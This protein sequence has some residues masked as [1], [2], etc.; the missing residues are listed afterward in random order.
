MLDGIAFDLIKSGAHSF[1]LRP[2]L[3]AY[4]KLKDK[5]RERHLEIQEIKIEF[6]D[7]ILVLHSLYSAPILDNLE[8][9]LR[10]IAGNWNDL[11]LT[12]GELPFEIHIS[13]LEDT[14]ESKTAKFRVIGEIDETITSDGAKDY[15]GYWGIIYD[16]ALQRRV[17]DVNQRMLIDE[18]FHTLNEHWAEVER[19]MTARS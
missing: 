13:V 4:R 1:I 9:V 5:N 8:A 12:S 14:T 15:F 17:Y 7:C 11:R 19:R 10:S 18:P 3:N 2:F 6:Q 16:R